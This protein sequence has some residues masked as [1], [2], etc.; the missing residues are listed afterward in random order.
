MDD[1][2]ATVA[3]LQA[4]CEQA[5][6]AKIRAEQ[7][8]EQAEHAVTEVAA[9]LKAEFGVTSPEQVRDLRTDLDKQIAAEVQRIEQA[10]GGPS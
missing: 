8:R 6:T 3:R 10:L 9:A 7:A 5:R 2:A 1:V 4:R